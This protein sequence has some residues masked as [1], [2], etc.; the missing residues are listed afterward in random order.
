MRGTT[1]AM[2]GAAKVRTFDLAWNSVWEKWGTNYYQTFYFTAESSALLDEISAIVSEDRLIASHLS[3]A[4]ASEDP[5][6]GASLYYQE[7]TGVDS[8]GRIVVSIRDISSTNTSSILL[9]PL[10]LARQSSGIWKCQN[11]RTSGSTA[12]KTETLSGHIYGS[13]YYLA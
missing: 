11:T 13:L 1:N 10:K 9:Q 3:G 8:N 5:I 7:I 6:Y 12:M 2:T 4:T